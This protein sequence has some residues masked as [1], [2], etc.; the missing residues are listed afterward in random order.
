MSPTYSASKSRSQNR[1]GWSMSFRHPLRNDSRG[2]P[3]VKMRRGLSTSDEEEADGLVAQMNRLLSDS[4][5]WNASRRREAEEQF[6]PVVVEAFFGEIQAGQEPSSRV[7]ESHI[8]LPARDQGYPRVLFVGTTGAGKTT[9]LRKL[10]GSDPD[11][12][13]FPST[14][15]AKTTI[16]DIEIVQA[17]GDFEAVVTFFSEFHTLANVEE[18]VAEACRTARAS[19]PDDRIAERL[20]NHRDQKFRLSYALGPWASASPQSDDDLSFEVG[21][22]PETHDDHGGLTQEASAANAMAL[23]KYVDRIRLLAQSVELSLRSEVSAWAAAGNDADREAAEELVEEEFDSTL[24]STEEFHELAQDILDALRSRFEAVA[25]GLEIAPSGWPKLWRCR[26]TEREAFLAKIR[27]FSSNYWPHFGRLLTP[28]VD[29]M[30]IRGPLYADFQDESSGFV[31]IDGQGLGHTPESSASV[32]THI[33]GRF[34]EVD[35]ILLVD[36]AQQPMQAAPLAVLQSLAASG[37]HRKLTIA[38]THFDQIRAPNLKALPDRRAHVMA[39]VTNALA[40]LRDILGVPVVKEIERT[41]EAHCFMLGGVDRAD[42]KLPPKAVEYMSGQLQALTGLFMESIRPPPPPEAKPIYDPT[43]IAFAVQEAVTKF[44][45]PWFARLG[46]STYAGVGKEHWTRIKALNRRIA[47]ELDVEYD[48][49]RPV[50]DL[51]A[52]FSVAISRYLDT[53]IHWTRKPLNEE[54]EQAAIAEIR[55]STSSVLHSL[56][57]ERLVGQHLEDWRTAYDTPAFRGPGSTFKRARAIEQI[58]EAATPVPD[59]AMTRP[60]AEFLAQ[61]RDILTKAIEN[62]GGQVQLAMSRPT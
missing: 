10:I 16:A 27:F 13:R 41:I 17:P 47:G 36:N 25:D 26:E 22:E 40:H 43:G 3:G 23:R 30:R 46:L 61:V 35:V 11:R 53:P 14:A 42:D 48:T 49:L 31:F 5:W 4:S 58:Y 1:T 20:L 24:T 52:R 12:D 18:C 38:F 37:H 34:D 7:R 59:A 6:A 44:Q 9:L 57:V 54:E 19:A 29:G 51:V 8:P 28:L 45:G 60:S 33:T 21:E 15:P 62:S 2:R 56:A 55:R 50:A 32:S 39:S